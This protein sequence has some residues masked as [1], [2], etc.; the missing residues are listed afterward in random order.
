MNILIKQITKDKYFILI[1]LLILIT[2]LLH[3]S[4][5][6]AEL[7]F[8]NFYRKLYYIPIILASFRY[9]LR[10]GIISSIF[11]SILYA[12]HLS[13][14]DTDLNIAL[15]NQYL[16]IILFLTI[17]FITGWLVEG[18]YKKQKLLENNIVEITRLQNYTQNIVDSIDNGVLAT[19]T[20]LIITALNREGEKILGVDDV[21]GLSVAAIFHN[22]IIDI[23][24]QTK[25]QR[26]RYSDVKTIINV[27]GEE[28]Y[29]NLTISPL[30]NILDRIQ[31]LVIVIDDLTNEKH[32][33][34]QTARADR[35][36]AIGEFASGIAHEIRN[37][38]GIIK[39]ISQTLQQEDDN[40]SIMEGLSIINMEIDRANRVIQSLLN[41]ARP[42]ANIMEEIDVNNLIKDVLLIINKF[43]S[44]Q[45]IEIK[46]IYSD[47]ILI[48]G[49]REKLKQ[50]F[51]NIILNS[52]QSMEEGGFISIKTE[53][54]DSGVSIYFKDNG[55]GISKEN[56]NKIFNPFFTTK[57]EG[58]GLGLA[59]SNR[60]IQDHNGYITIDSSI[61]Q[62]SLVVIY[63]PIHE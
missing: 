6:M 17:G 27:E 29:L 18:D 40:E 61:N 47:E 45:D 44:K 23:L 3:Y 12:P 2:T 32:L 57:E 33:E 35:L 14:L 43:A 10:G 7:E 25:L 59:V 8:H 19:D 41:F 39:T 37:P 54:S 49:D 20:N 42:D 63:L 34:A 4:N 1:V 24:N 15:I 55:I 21:T 11:I 38:M 26:F 5:F 50:V 58:T 36:S 52:I 62:G 16:E 53:S 9:R 13:L 22:D 48:M 60:I 56:I 30:L 51:I 28:R 31:G 46:P